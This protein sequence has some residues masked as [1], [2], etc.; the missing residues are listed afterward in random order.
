MDCSHLKTQ[1][2]N[3]LYVLLVFGQD[4]TLGILFPNKGQLEEMRTDP[5]VKIPVRQKPTKLTNL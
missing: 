1:K 2:V 5:D 4:K 3:A